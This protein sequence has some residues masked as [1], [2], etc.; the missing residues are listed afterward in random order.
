MQSMRSGRASDIDVPSVVLRDFFGVMST[1]LLFIIPLLTMGVYAEE[2]KRGTMELLMTSPVTDAQ[3]V[4]GK[5]FGSVT[6]LVMMLLPTA[7][8]QVYM[9][10][11][12]EPRPP[13]NVLAAGYLGMLLLGAVLLAIGSFLSS[14]T[15]NQLIASVL[16]F[17]TFLLLWVIDL[18]Q[19]GASGT[20]ASV[21]QYFS[22]VQHYDDFTHGVIDTT[23]L[24]FYGSLIVLGIYLTMRSI[25]SMRWRR[26]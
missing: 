25:D 9:F 26:A 16:T 11:H 1:L 18:G 13:W 22:I 10:A 12:S 21:L 20:L 17:G 19:R 23:S 7:G 24:V 4:L 5:F 15:E 6:L 3:I 2:R 8:Y 14:V